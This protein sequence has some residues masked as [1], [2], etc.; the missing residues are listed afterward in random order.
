MVV[1]NFLNKRSFMSS[2]GRARQFCF[3]SLSTGL[4]LIALQSGRLQQAA[5]ATAQTP[6]ATEAAEPETVVYGRPAQGTVSAS[7]PEQEWLF[8]PN[9][10][11]RITITVNRTS[12]TLVPALELQDEQ[13]NVVAKADHDPTYARAVIQNFTMPEP[14][15][16]RVLVGRYDGPS[17]KTVG[18]YTMVISLLGAGEDG[19]SPTFVEGLIHLGQPRDGTVSEA[20]WL[21]TWAFQTVGTDPVT[22]TVSRVR[23]TLV[24]TLKLSDANWKPV[25]SGTLDETFAVTSIT[26]FVPAA[27]S[28]YYVTITRL[29]GSKGGTTGDYRLTVVQGTSS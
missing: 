13:G 11:D 1:R 7:S 2:P 15:R 6:P 12:D 5:S 23:G 9:S 3:L 25:A 19:F 24:P 26:N 18:K 8:L 16:Y 4:M 20:K 21:D 22:I 27:A 17:G 10:K 29:D 14:G 28:Q